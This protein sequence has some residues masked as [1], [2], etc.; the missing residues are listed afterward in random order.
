MKN[1]IQVIEQIEHDLAALKAAVLS[2][3]KT[4]HKD[5]GFNINRQAMQK[6]ILR[7]LSENGEMTRHN[8]TAKFR[9]RFIS[10]DDVLTVLDAMESEGM[11]KK[12]V[13]QGVG[14]PLTTY[15]KS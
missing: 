15:K 12:N 3:D 2:D 4:M 14:R 1:I 7:T 11:L 10:R 8:L 5:V 13:S 6:K 9:T